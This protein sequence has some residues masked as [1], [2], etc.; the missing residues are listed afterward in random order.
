MEF[1]KTLYFSKANLNN[2]P[3]LFCFCKHYNL[4]KLQIVVC[5]VIFYEI[6]VNQ[7]NPRT[8]I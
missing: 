8:I 5:F 4:G 6:N 7:D 2:I 3:D 1:A